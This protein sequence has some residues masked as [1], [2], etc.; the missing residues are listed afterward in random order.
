[1]AK[2]ATLKA[3]PIILAW[4]LGMFKTLKIKKSAVDKPTV[5]SKLCSVFA[6]RASL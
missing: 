6:T 4:G 3:S 1:M 5:A 2:I